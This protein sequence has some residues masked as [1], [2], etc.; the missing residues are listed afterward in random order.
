M[1]PDVDRESPIRQELLSAAECVADRI[2]GL[3]ALGNSTR[4]ILSLI[5]ICT[6]GAADANQV[7]FA[8]TI[9]VD[10]FSF[11]TLAYAGDADGK[12]SIGSRCV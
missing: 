7:G 1:S 3:Y 8:G 4:E 5:H 12:P 6:Q 9:A 10:H 11:L 2:I